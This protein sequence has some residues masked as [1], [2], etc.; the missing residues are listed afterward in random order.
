MAVEKGPKGR[1]DA[2]RPTLGRSGRDTPR[3]KKAPLFRDFAARYRE[4]SKHR[5]KPSSLK[6]LHIYLRNRL[7]PHFGRLR[8]DHD[9]PCAR[10]GMVRRGECGQPCAANRGFEIL[11]AMLAAARQW[12]EIGEHIPVA[13]ANAVRNPRC[14]VPRYLNHPE[15]ERLGTVLDRHWHE[16][17]WSVAATRLLTLTGARVFPEDLTRT[18][19]TRHTWASQG[20]MNDVRLDNG[21][22]QLLGHRQRETTP[23]YAHLEDG[24]LREA[25]AQVAAVIARAM[26]IQ[27]RAASGAGRSGG[28]RY[29]GCHA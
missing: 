19:S 20:A 8:L 10:L 4:R 21:R 22:R 26:R 2:P 15:L 25:V 6:T 28:R 29:L 11:R 5:W 18:G 3:K 17:P 16:Y 14:P 1:C 7:I 27:G 9:R 13:C 12:G 23:I 24:A